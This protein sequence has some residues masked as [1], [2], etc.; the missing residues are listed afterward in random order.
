M[1]RKGRTTNTKP[2]TK[3]KATEPAA[4]TADAKAG[5]GELLLN[6]LPWANVDTVVDE[7]QVAVKLPADTS[8]PFVLP[9]PVGKYTVTFKNPFAATKPLTVTATVDAN[10]RASAV[11]TFPTTSA[12]GY[13]TRAGW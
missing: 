9:L 3:S 10:R 2:E 11:V 6:A 13:L 7:A 5:A 4:T 12:Q 8:T 1:S